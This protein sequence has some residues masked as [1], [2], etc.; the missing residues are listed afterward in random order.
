MSH[1]PIANKVVCID[2]D[3]TIVPWGPLMAPKDP[4]PGVAN[5]IRELK[6]AGYRIVIFTSR[7]S[8][9]W[10]DDEDQDLGDQLAYV[11]GI[12]TDH[13]IPFDDITADK[14]PAEAYFD[15]RAIRVD[16]SWPLNLAIEGFLLMN[17]NAA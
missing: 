13:L 17:E 3:G 5:A 16:E 9:T 2:F 6:K 7:L 11:A 15:D 14:V 12:L 8:E 4:F 1:P 10:I